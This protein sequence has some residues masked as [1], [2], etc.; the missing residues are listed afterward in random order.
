MPHYHVQQL[1]TTSAIITAN[2]L[3]LGGD[4]VEIALNLASALGGQ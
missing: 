2:L 1:Q 4:L 3:V